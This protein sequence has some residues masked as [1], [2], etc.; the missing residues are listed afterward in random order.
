MAK[1]FDS[2]Q[3]RVRALQLLGKDLVRRAR[4]RC[5]LTGTSGVPLQPYEIP[6]VPAEPDLARTLLLSKAA[7]AAIEKP[8]SIDAR[9][10][11]CLNEAVWSDFPAL[12]VVAWRLL[13]CIG[14]QENWAREI[15]D[16]VFLDPDVEAWARSS[17][18]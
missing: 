14:R 18:L 1:G 11:R 10:W 6:P 13:E 7:I 2:N 3:E 12:Q 15:L 5:E 8:R 17:L 4:S 16:E 9:E